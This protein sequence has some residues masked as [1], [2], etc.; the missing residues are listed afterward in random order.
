M[1]WAP[2][3]V[4]QQDRELAG[5]RPGGF[6]Q[7]YKCWET[8]PVPVQAEDKEFG[9]SVTRPWVEST[10]PSAGRMETGPVLCALGEQWG[11]TCSFKPRSS[12]SAQVDPQ[13]LLG[14]LQAPLW[15]CFQ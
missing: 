4:L 11:P 5:I 12:K 3:E 13:A 9:F 6:M 15:L 10:F 7:C 2:A 8:A 14:Q 1:A